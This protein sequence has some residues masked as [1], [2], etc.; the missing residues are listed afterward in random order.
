MRGS[1]R[2]A[3]AFWVPILI[4]YAKIEAGHRFSISLWKPPIFDRCT[5][6]RRSLLVPFLPL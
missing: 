3:A 6:D 4:D 2:T 5:L 1:R